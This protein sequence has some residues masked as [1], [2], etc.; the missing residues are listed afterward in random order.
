[1]IKFVGTWSDFKVWLRN[2]NNKKNEE[3]IRYEL[4]TRYLSR[5]GKS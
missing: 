1:M 5:L 2:K 3:R 4:Y